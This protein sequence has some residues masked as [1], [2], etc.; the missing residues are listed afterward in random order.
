M[1]K[2]KVTFPNILGYITIIICVIATAYLYWTA[3]PG[4][5]ALQLFISR[6]WEWVIIII[7]VLVGAILALVDFGKHKE[8]QGFDHENGTL[9]DAQGLIIKPGPGVHSGSSVCNIC[10]SQM[11]GC[12]ATVCYVCGYTFCYE[13]SVIAEMDGH[14]VWACK[15]CMGL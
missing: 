12:W 5:N 8:C 2:S 15:R 13:C 7:V 10:G 6:F 4:L 9:Y 14:E 3:P 1:K 11:P